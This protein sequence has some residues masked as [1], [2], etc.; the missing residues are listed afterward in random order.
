MPL[1]RLPKPLAFAS[2]VQ[3][4]ETFYLVGGTFRETSNY[5]LLTNAIH[6]FDPVAWKWVTLGKA[7]WLSSP[8]TRLAA[9]AVD[10][11]VFP[12]CC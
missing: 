4:G 8:R 6:K 2:S 9:F 3:V 12:L 1:P 10:S 5:S 7:S 11:R